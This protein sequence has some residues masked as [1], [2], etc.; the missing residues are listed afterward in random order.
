MITP[1]RECQ[2]NLSCRTCSFCILEAS[3]S[4]LY[5]DRTEELNIELI[6]SNR[7]IDVTT[8]SSLHCNDSCN[9]I[10]QILVT[11]SVQ[12]LL[13]CLV[14]CVCYDA[15][16]RIQA[17]NY[18]SQLL[19]GVNL[20]AIFASEETLTCYEAE[21]QLQL[22]VQVSVWSSKRINWKLVAYESILQIEYVLI[23][24]TFCTYNLNVTVNIVIT[25]TSYS[26]ICCIPVLLNLVLV[27]E[28]C[29]WLQVDSRW[30]PSQL[31][32]NVLVGSSLTSLQSITNVCWQSCLTSLEC[33][34]SS[35]VLD[36][37]SDNLSLLT[38]YVSCC[39]RYSTNLLVC[40]QC[41]SIGCSLFELV[42]ICSTT[43]KLVSI[44]ESFLRHVELSIELL[45]NLCPCYLLEIDVIVTTSDCVWLVN[46]YQ[47]NFLSLILSYSLVDDNLDVTNSSNLVVDSILQDNTYQWLT[48]DS[49]LI[50]SC[51]VS[52]LLTT[53]C[54]LWAECITIRCDCSVSTLWCLV[55]TRLVTNQ[56]ER[57]LEARLL[58]EAFGCIL[59]PSLTSRSSVLVCAVSVDILTEVDTI[60]IPSYMD[61]CVVIDSSLCC[62]IEVWRNSINMLQCWV[63]QNQLVVSASL[64][65][66][67]VRSNNWVARSIL[68]CKNSN[69]FTICKILDGITIILSVY[70]NLTLCCQ[71]CALHLESRT[72]ISGSPW[73]IILV[74]CDEAIL[75]SIVRH[76]GIWWVQEIGSSQVWSVCERIVSYCRSILRVVAISVNC[77][78]CCRVV[79]VSS[80]VECFDTCIIEVRIEYETLQCAWEANNDLLARSTCYVC[81]SQVIVVPNC[82]DDIRVSCCIDNLRVVCI[83]VTVT[84][85]PECASVRIRNVVLAVFASSTSLTLVT[86]GSKCI[87]LSLGVVL[88]PITIFTNLPNVTVLASS[89][90]H[91]LFDVVRSVRAV[92]CNSD[93]DT[94]ITV[95]LYAFQDATIINLCL[96]LAESLWQIVNLS[97]QIVDVII[98]IFT[99][100]KCAYGSNCQCTHKQRAK[101]LS[102]HR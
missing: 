44:L 86:L 96:Q 39:L 102:F 27:A 75:S 26:A 85:Y 32:V 12:Q 65:S 67:E 23:V 83:L 38:R 46:C 87:V 64:D 34:V 95:G 94:T 2:V 80:E 92:L 97:L 52:L 62:L 9:G 63:I 16:N 93:N 73:H 10:L 1:V 19:L 28:C 8:D 24:C 31:H 7:N 3:C 25:C 47:V 71:V 79:L 36:R 49:S 69:L 5:V 60:A 29:R 17:C 41:L 22:L 56:L 20:R 33:S 90:L 4:L 74:I 70:S 37:P 15:S 78:D 40:C 81:Q 82:S 51:T 100:S 18:I 101:I 6:I 45:L 76:L 13:C 91:A 14:L 50:L 30:S 61:L 43:V 54:H 84:I 59:I 58:Y 48:T 98:V 89:A 66:C 35:L 77:L 21:C 57:V 68:Q 99:R 53:S 72:V 11:V 42:S 55:S 88:V